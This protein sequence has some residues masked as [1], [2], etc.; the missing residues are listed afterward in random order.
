[1]SFAIIT[2]LRSLTGDTKLSK[3][4]RVMWLTYN[5]M[6]SCLGLLND[7]WIGNKIPRNYKIKLSKYRLHRNINYLETP[8]RIAT[9]IYLESLIKEYKVDCSAKKIIL[10]IGC[11]SGHYSEY[12]RGILGDDIEYHGFDVK[13]CP[14]NLLTDSSYGKSIFYH[15]IENF[16]NVIK[17]MDKS[18]KIY[19]FSLSV[20]EHIENPESFLNKISKALIKFKNVVHFHCVPSPLCIFTYPVHGYRQFPKSLLLGYNI[21]ALNKKIIGV[22]TPLVTIYHALSI[23]M[24]RQLKLKSLRSSLPNVYKRLSKYALKMDFF[25]SSILGNDHPFAAFYIFILEK[26]HE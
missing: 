4:E 8:T 5:S 15:H 26:N 12:F 18:A 2:K 13:S 7:F 3:I 17:E 21:Y 14:S 19:V 23:S 11:G 20:L 1:M 10:D 24:P 6:I 25:V 16:E 22:G 9:D